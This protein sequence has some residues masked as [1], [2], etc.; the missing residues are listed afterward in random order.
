MIGR[1]GVGSVVAFAVA[2]CGGTSLPSAV[3]VVGMET[4]PPPITA[5]PVEDD[6]APTTA[7]ST[8]TTE[9]P[10]GPVAA[11]DWVDAVDNLEGLGSTCANV[12]NVTVD[13]RTG[14]VL[15]SVPFDGM[16]RRDHDADE[17]V[18]VGDSADVVDHRTSWIEFDPTDPDRYWMS[19]AYGTAIYR[20]DD[21]GATFEPIPDVIHADRVAVDMTDPERRLMLV[22]LHEQTALLKSTDGGQTWDDISGTLPPGVGFTSVPVIL[23]ADTYLVGTYRGEGAGVYRTENGGETWT[24]VYEGP[25]LGTPVVT[26]SF[27]AWNLETGNSGLAVSTDAGESFRAAGGST[28][29]ASFTLVDIGNG[30][31]AAPSSNGVVVTNDLGVSWRTIGDDLDFRPWGV[32]YDQRRD[33]LY[34]WW[35]TCAVEAAGNV[36]VPGQI[37]RLSVDWSG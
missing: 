33:E 1:L 13:P 4:V 28:G 29:N 8:A 24:R 19:G 18:L 10:V 11:G 9:A 12:S 36:I 20:T 22:G 31:L 15:A 16:F 23:D 2:A 6:P 37:M 5:A 14:D 35:F 32:A 26:D 7:I 30:Y 21:G 34:A 25:V 17:W 3:S 27:I